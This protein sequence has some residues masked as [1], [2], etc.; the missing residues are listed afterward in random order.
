MITSDSDFESSNS[1]IDSLAARPLCKTTLISA[2]LYIGAKIK[3]IA[4]I[5]DINVPTE[6]TSR[7]SSEVTKYITPA[8]FERLVIG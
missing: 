8:K 7:Y 2:N 1:K 6:I 5:N 4:V 3:I